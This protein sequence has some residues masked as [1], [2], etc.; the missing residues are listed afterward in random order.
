[1]ITLPEGCSVWL[2]HDLRSRSG[3]VDGMNSVCGGLAACEMG[4]E[5][6]D[7]PSRE[8]VEVREDSSLDEGVGVILEAAARGSGLER[9]DCSPERGVFVPDLNALLYSMIRK[10]FFGSLLDVMT[11]MTPAAVAISAAMSLV[12]IPP[13]PRFDPRVFVL[14]FTQLSAHERSAVS[15]R[16]TLRTNGRDGCH[17]VYSR[18]IG[19][20]PR[21]RRV[22]PI[23]IS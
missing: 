17:D 6:E 15:R 8:G 13:V 2:V 18:S 16:P 11:V 7:T 10:I 19:V 23:H 14:T 1:M 22:Q 9:P 20:F 12:S 21:I 5:D 4:V 3:I